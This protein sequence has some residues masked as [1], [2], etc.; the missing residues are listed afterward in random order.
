MTD[1]VD[2]AYWFPA[3]VKAGVPHPKTTIIA[4]SESERG[5]LLVGSMEGEGAPVTDADRSACVSIGQRLRDAAVEINP[6]GP[7]FLRNG[8]FSGKHDFDSCCFVKD[9]DRFLN[10]AMSIIYVGEC[11]SM[12][13]FPIEHWVVREYLNVAPIFTAF[14]STPIVREFRLFAKDG[15]VHQWQPY[16][17]AGSIQDPSVPDWEDRLAVAS[18]FTES[19]ALAVHGY[20]RDVTH[21]LSGDSWSIDFLCDA[22]G[23]WFLT[24]MAIEA[25]SYKDDG[26]REWGDFDVNP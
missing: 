5:S 7:W 11:V 6:T 8:H 13:G 24:D 14:G 9:Q 15:A 22:D 16:W 26:V 19:D 1:K 20:C 17:P 23:K 21:L 4:L 2:M 3:V 10:H 18:L 25:Q 12:I